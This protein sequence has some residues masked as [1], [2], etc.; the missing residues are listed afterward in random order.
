MRIRLLTPVT[1][2]TRVALTL[3][4][5]GALAAPAPLGAQRLYAFG[6]ALPE[7]SL[8]GAVH[9]GRVRS[10]AVHPRDRRRIAIAAEFGG[11]WRSDD[12]GTT[13][14]HA[15]G[16]SATLAVDVVYADGGATLVATT[17]RDLDR[18][19][20][21]GGGGVWVSRDDGVTWRP[22][23]TL[24]LPGV[25]YAAADRPSGHGLSVAPDDDR[26]V[27]AGTDYGIAISRD[28]GA[29]WTPDRPVL[30]IIADA[31]FDRAI[32]VL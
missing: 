15:G 11:V 25:E 20:P 26:F 24:R 19:R 31:A 10:I 3:A 12:G 32:S 30:P 14:W 2:A 8:F 21:G 9:G 5:S 13:W 18:A 16:L 1:V 23:D 4:V 17:E 28:A 22:V 7:F 6:P 29:T 27:V